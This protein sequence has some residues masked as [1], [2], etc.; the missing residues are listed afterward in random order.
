MS[1]RLSGGKSDDRQKLKQWLA[2]AEAAGWR[3]QPS[4]T[5]WMLLD[6]TGVHH[7]GVHTTYSDHRSLMNLRARFKRAGLDVEAPLVKE[8]K[9][10]P[11]QMPLE[12]IERPVVDN[13]IE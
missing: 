2:A 5:G 9:P 11:E 3:R 6:P 12:L 10:M 13:A 1:R 4:K 7:V 8:K